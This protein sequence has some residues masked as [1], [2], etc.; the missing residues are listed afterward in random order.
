MHNAAFDQLGLDWHYEALAVEPARFEEEV[1][2][3]AQGAYA[4]ANVT[5]PHKVAAL[6]L[7]T[8]RDAVA[9]GVGAA[10]TL[11]FTE[12][13]IAAHNTDVEGFLRA[14]RERR[15]EAPGQMDALVL[16][17]GGAA[18]AVVYAL[19]EHGAGRIEVWNR[20]HDRA[21][22]L[23]EELGQGR[24]E[25]RLRTVV[26]PL[27]SGAQLLVNTTSVGMVE[28]QEG[29][30]DED[31]QELHLSADKWN[32]LQMVVDLAYREGSTPLVRQ[33]KRRGLS[34]V[35]GIDILVHQGAASFELWTGRKA[36]LEVMSHAARER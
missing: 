23:V 30:G 1:R 20:S 13:Q 2:R 18:R 10:N 16:G 24:A 14:V 21:R 22:A 8:S 32:D 35:D 28:R 4:G 11:V 9:E 12:G 25:E 29:G 15:P 36:P 6:R 7:A 27:E 33:A 17:A 34:H 3:L 31:L 19:L 5:I 26:E